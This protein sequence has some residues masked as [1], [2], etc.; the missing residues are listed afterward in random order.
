MHHIILDNFVLMSNSLLIVCCLI[1]APIVAGMWSFFRVIFL[2][3]IFGLVFGVP[4]FKGCSLAQI[5]RGALGDLSIT[6]SLVLLF[7]LYARL[8]ERISINP[9]NKY[10][11]WVIFLMGCTLYA[12]SL[13]FIGVDVYSYGY[14]LKSPVI[15][16][17]SYAVIQLILWHFNKVFAFIWL[18]AM[19]SFILKLQGSINL[20]DY[21]FDPV[22]WFISFCTIVNKRKKTSTDI[23]FEYN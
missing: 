4:I 2:A 20:W 23:I 19:I 11:A 6:T 7:W 8:S 1:N 5:M 21:L 22:L 13:G 9:M 18:V 17:V 15:V 10:I 14:L 16:L 12:S 3:V